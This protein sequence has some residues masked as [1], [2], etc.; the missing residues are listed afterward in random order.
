[1]RILLALLVPLFPI[2]IFYFLDKIFN[3][4]IKLIKFFKSIKIF[5]TTMFVI[6]VISCILITIFVIIAHNNLLLA[7]PYSPV[8]LYH[9][10]M[11]IP[12]ELR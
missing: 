9:Y 11:H 2:L 12:K 10:L 6:S 1:M 4:K 8:L 3:L 5:K 7:F